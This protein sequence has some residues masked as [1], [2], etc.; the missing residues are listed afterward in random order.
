MVILCYHDV[1]PN[2]QRG[3]LETT[4][5]TPKA[6]GSGEGTVGSMSKELP[7]T[8]KAGARVE[9]P[10]EPG[11][12]SPTQH[13]KEKAGKKTRASRGKSTGCSRKDSGLVCLPGETNP[14]PEQAPGSVFVL[15]PGM[16]N[17]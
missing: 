2:N 14:L 15:S 5:P 4:S 6:S 3:Q 13:N 10:E 8:S 1:A 7:E 11:L 16:V 17:G 9:W 12:H